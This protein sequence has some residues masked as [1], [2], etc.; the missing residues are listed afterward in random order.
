M[1]QGRREISKTEEKRT[2]HKGENVKN[3][4]VGRADRAG[5]DR[6]SVAG[7]DGGPTAVLSASHGALR[8]RGR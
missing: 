7:T 2:E 6:G 1:M 3:H 8:Q 5:F 4:V